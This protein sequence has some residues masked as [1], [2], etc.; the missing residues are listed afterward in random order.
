MSETKL[1]LA[2]EVVAFAIKC[3]LTAAQAEE[4]ARRA[5]ITKHPQGNR[6]YHNWLFQINGTYVVSMVNLDVPAAKEAPPTKV[7][8]KE[9]VMYDECPKCEGEGCEA[10]NHTGQ[11]K[12]V[13]K[14]QSRKFF[15]R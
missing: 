3:N 4:M 10:C 13:H 9:F 7:G 5:A 12:A 15:N 8:E 1:I 6:R 11:V 2:P 14:E